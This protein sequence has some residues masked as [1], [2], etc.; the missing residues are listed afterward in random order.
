MAQSYGCRRDELHTGTTDA[1]SQVPAHMPAMGAGAG[2]A[3]F[4]AM[5]KMD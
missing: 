4:C 5:R 2:A 1:A 3:G